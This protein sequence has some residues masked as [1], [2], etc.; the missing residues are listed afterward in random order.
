[1]PDRNLVVHA[2]MLVA[3]DTVMHALTL[4]EQLVAG[5]DL[6]QAPDCLLLLA[7]GFVVDVGNRSSSPAAAADRV[8]LAQRT[9]PFLA[10]AFQRMQGAAVERH[11]RVLG[12][13]NAQMVDQVVHL[14]QRHR[15]AG[16]EARDLPPPGGGNRVASE[17]ALPDP[18]RYLDALGLCARDRIP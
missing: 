15:I 16:E 9:M 13:G 12:F 10:P 14:V 2:E 18:A 8:M 3:R 17:R 6:A 1:G 4:A 11:S 5:L 7:A